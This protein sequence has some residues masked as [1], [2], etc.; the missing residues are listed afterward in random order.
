MRR[1]E[2]ADLEEHVRTYREKST[3]QRSTA[4]QSCR[5]SDCVGVDEYVDG[6]GVGDVGANIAAVVT[7]DAKWVRR[8]QSIPEVC[9]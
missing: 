7:A 2:R 9:D 6:G 5:D 3:P 4:R 1:L 8:A